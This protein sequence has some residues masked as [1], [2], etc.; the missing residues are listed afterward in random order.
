MK[1]KILLMKELGKNWELAWL[2]GSAIQTFSGEK[3]IIQFTTTYMGAL[4]RGAFSEVRIIYQNGS[5]RCF[6]KT[7]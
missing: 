3:E 6:A 7:F 4:P 5:W 1:G 2:D